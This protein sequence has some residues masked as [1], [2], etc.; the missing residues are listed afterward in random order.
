M[1]CGTNGRKPSLGGRNIIIVRAS[2]RAVRIIDVARVRYSGLPGT[3]TDTLHTE[4]IVVGH[5]GACGET[6]GFIIQQKTALVGDLQLVRALGTRLVLVG[7]GTSCLLLHQNG[8]LVVTCIESQVATQRC[9]L[10][11]RCC[12]VLTVHLGHI[13]V[14]PSIGT[15]VHQAVLHRLLETGVASSLDGKRG[16]AAAG[17]GL[18]VPAILGPCRLSCHQCHE[19]QHQGEDSVKLF[20]H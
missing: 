7:I 4:D 5:R 10:L 14:L 1:K 19:C 20:S 18:D 17:A 13:V 15:Q 2:H 8:L 6:T 3:N 9:G 16:H 11:F 12:F